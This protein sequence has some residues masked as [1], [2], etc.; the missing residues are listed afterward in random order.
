MNSFGTFKFHKF[1][2][3]PLN[4]NDSMEIS[5]YFINTLN[6]NI[7]AHNYYN[8]KEEEKDKDNKKESNYN[9]TARQF[10]NFRTNNNNELIINTTFSLKEIINLDFENIIKSK[11]GIFKIRNYLPQM[12]YLNLDDN[13]NAS[14][15]K[16]KY[17]I[18]LLKHFQHIIQYLSDTE[19]NMN[20]FNVLL[21]QTEKEIIINKEQ[22]IDNELKINKTIEDNDN[23][24][25]NLENKINIYKKIILTATSKTSQ[26]PLIYNVLDIHDN[27]NNY[28]CDL[29]AN[30]IFKSYQEVKNH[31][32][33]EHIN[34][35]KRREKNH[36]YLNDI[37]V[38]NI[39]Y[40]N[41]Y[42]DTKLN[43]IKKEIKYLLLEINSKKDKVYDNNKINNY[44]KE[45]NFIQ[46]NKNTKNLSNKDLLNFNYF[47]ED[48]FKKNEIEIIDYENKFNNFEKIQKNYNDNLQKNFDTFKNEI[49]AQLKILKNKSSNIINNTTKNNNINNKNIKEININ[50]KIKEYEFN[51]NIKENNL[52]KDMKNNKDNS[53]INDNKNNE[54]FKGFGENYDF[55]SPQNSYY[56]KNYKEMFKN[57]NMNNNDINN[58]NINDNINYI[59]QN[60]KIK[61]NEKEDLKI[62]EYNNEINKNENN[63]YNIKNEN[64]NEK[65]ENKINLKQKNNYIDIIE[66]NKF[67]NNFSNRENTVLFNKNID[68]FKELNKN[69]NILKNQNM[70]NITNKTEQIIDKAKIKYNLKEDNTK[71]KEEYKQII[72]DILR[73]NGD[74]TNRIHHNYFDNLLLKMNL[75]KCLENID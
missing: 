59:N 35:L 16:N 51:N 69:Y 49:F 26:N 27:N 71:T 68:D 8:I 11:A 32:I 60:N 17:F 63:I 10:H 36:K 21:K 43:E 33:N 72:N 34:I 44:K 13:L 20:N 57:N 58:N 3:I 66:I 62:N 46:N 70:K 39:N 31:Y 56:E 18:F 28:Y 38:N 48:D 24:I 67:A 1:S 22:Y 52:N 53:N 54:G 14:F 5:R 7:L 55:S 2:E 65:E 19:K 37:S 75:K 4:T 47:Q 42:F 9:L 15:K 25:F 12:T 29:C 50:N 41:F 23:K 6:N 40:E 73:D 61:K 74:L 64:K 45:Y 30:K